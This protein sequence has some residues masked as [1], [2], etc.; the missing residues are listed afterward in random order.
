MNREGRTVKSKLEQGFDYV[1]VSAIIIMIAALV[2]T[3]H[4]AVRTGKVTT[5]CLAYGW[6]G[7]ETIFLGSAYCTRMEGTAKIVKPLGEVLAE[8]NDGD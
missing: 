4:M 3:V 2:C 8:Q 5:Q 6:S 1:F 7:A